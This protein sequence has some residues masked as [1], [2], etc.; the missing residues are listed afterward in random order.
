LPRKQTLV[1]GE[2]CIANDRALL[3]ALE[4]HP[5]G[6]QIAIQLRFGI[7]LNRLTRHAS[8]V[9]AAA[10]D[11]RLTGRHDTSFDD[12]VDRDLLGKHADVALN[13]AIDCDLPATD[14]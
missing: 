14:V 8:A 3:R 10:E 11:N 6:E 12:A 1:S 5:G 7:E 9:G 4:A 2:E 13:G